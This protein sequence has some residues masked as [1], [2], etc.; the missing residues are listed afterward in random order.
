MFKM[1]K[2]LKCLKKCLLFKYNF[3]IKCRNH[4]HGQEFF[5]DPWNINEIDNLI[6]LIGF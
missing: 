3:K 5:K 6:L 2:C 1:F 4:R